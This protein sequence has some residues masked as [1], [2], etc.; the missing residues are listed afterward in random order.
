MSIASLIRSEVADDERRSGG[1]E[2][3]LVAGG[4]FHFGVSHPLYDIG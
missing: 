4:W 3:Q 1:A 2:G